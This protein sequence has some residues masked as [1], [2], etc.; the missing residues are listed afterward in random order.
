MRVVAMA[1]LIL[2]VVTPA[3]SDDVRVSNSDELA[4][5]VARA[6]PGTRVLLAPGTYRG[7]LSRR[8]LQGTKE[9]PIVLQSADA[10]TPA[11]VEGGGSG[12]H[13]SSPAWVEV[14]DLVFSGA[15]ANGLNIDDG[16]SKD[17]PAH[18]VTLSGLVVQ[19]NGPSGNRDGIK[20]SGLADFAVENCTV[21]RW[22][23]SGSGIDMVGCRNGT[24]VGCMFKHSG[25]DY[26]NGVQA[27]G[28]SEQITIRR[29]RFEDAGGRALNLG[30]S[31]GL[32]YFRPKP[33]GYEAKDITVE[34]CT[35][36]GS[37]AAIAFVGVDGAIVRFNTIY[38]PTRWVIRILQENQD[39]SFVPCRKGRFENNL[40]AFQSDEVRATVNVGGGT[41]PETFVFQ[42]NVW[43][44]LDRPS[45][46]QRL[47]E[48]PAKETRGRYDLEVR[49]RAPEKGDYRPVDSSHGRSGIRAE[50][51]KSSFVPR[52]LGMEL[53]VLTSPD[54]LDDY[55]GRLV[56]VRG[57]IL[58][59]KWKHLAGV[60]V[61]ADDSLI[62][63]E[64]YAIGI[65]IR[66]E[67]KGRTPGIQSTGSKVEYLLY[68]DVAGHSA[69][70]ERIPAPSP[71]PVQQTSP[72][73]RQRN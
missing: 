65:L 45:S 6:R 15:D 26:A 2:C 71:S 50:S 41:S 59:T 53:P 12:L 70:A 42:E 44:C 39:K 8:G 29:C 67:K 19:N 51:A 5:A 49:F 62:G 66:F 22:G 69:K 21:E 20:L 36:V 11:V 37:M 52:A 73:V 40:V 43:T 60:Q 1:A 24:V 17:S 7:G 63:H 55:L 3:L 13:L 33:Q 32:D 54:Q 23:T 28:G 27:K 68:S 58:N 57:E 47:V 56:A 61:E 10:K 72:Q 35:I 25:A 34:D 38:R 30:G 9:Q 46:T 4:A 31:T 16:G 48:L 64:A 18:H 14:R